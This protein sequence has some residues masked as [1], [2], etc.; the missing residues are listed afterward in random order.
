M[1]ILKLLAITLPILMTIWSCNDEGETEPEEVGTFQIYFDNKVGSSD[2]NLKAAG[3]TEYDFETSSGEAFNI[4]ML[5]YYVSKI[6]LTGP[7]GEL[8]EDEVLVNADDAR[9]YYHILEGTSTTQNIRLKNVPAGTYDKLTFTIGVAE[10]GMQEG[11][12]GGVLDPA[13][14]GWFWNW[15]AGFIGLA[16]EGNAENSGQQYVDWGNGSETLAKTYAIHIGGWKDVEGNENFVNNV[17]TITVDFGTTVSVAEELSP[18]AHV[19]VDVLKMLEGASIDFSS[20]YSIHSPKGGKTFAD[21]LDQ[22]FS[23]HHIHQST[24]GH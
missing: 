2:I 24:S 19:V 18:L 9:G 16:L 8:Y 1:E 10:D 7:N 3:S 11:A 23:V 6:S 5:G 12:I 13:N 14:S 15:N 17:K 21:Q 22:V 4:S 20:S